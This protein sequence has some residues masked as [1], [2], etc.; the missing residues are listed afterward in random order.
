[1]DIARALRFCLVLGVCFPGAAA[2]SQLAELQ[3][4]ARVRI[5]A[6]GEIAGRLTGVV[7]ARSADSV[8]I[9][10][11]GGTPVAVALAKLST[12]DISRGKSRGA[13]ALKGVAWGAAVGLGLGAIGPVTEV[14][15]S[16]VPTRCA[17]VSRG[18]FIGTMVLGSTIIGAAIGAVIGSERWAGGV[19]PT[20]VALLPPSRGQASGIMLSWAVGA[21][22]PHD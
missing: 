18:S 17:P 16:G 9:T 20:R 1:M 21:A 10:R 15:C 8:T 6:P 13:G 5:R 4:G 11:S 3:P 7:V 22:R 12:L 19:L 2:H 14:T